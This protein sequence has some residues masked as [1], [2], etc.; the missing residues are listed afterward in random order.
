MDCY[1]YK[2]KYKT[3]GFIFTKSDQNYNKTE[4]YKW[5][6]PEYLTIDFLAIKDQEVKNQYI[7]NVGITIDMASKFNLVTNDAYS[8]LINPF[9]FKMDSYKPV[10]FYNSLKP[11]IYYYADD[12]M[13][14]LSGKIIELSLDKNL[15]WK[16][17]KIRTDR[18]VELQSGKYFGNNYRVAEITLQSIINPLSLKELIS[19]HN[20]LINNMYFT[21]QD[22]TYADIKKFNNYVKRMLIQRYQNTKIVLDLASGRA[23]DLNKYINANVKN[24]IMLEIDKDA[25][26]E[27]INR[28]Y[29][30]LTKPY[31]KGCNLV[32]L[33]TDLNNTYTNNIKLIDDA[34][35]DSDTFI[36]NNNIPTNGL[37]KLKHSI[38]VIFCH[39]AFHYMLFN[40]KSTKNIISFIDHYLSVNGVFIITIFNAQNVFQLL[41]LHKG[42][43][44]NN[45]YKIEY[46]G[47]MP[48]IFSGFGHI[49]DVL[50]PLSNKTQKEPL[51]DLFALDKI[52]NIFNIKR[53]EEKNFG[54]V[55]MDNETQHKFTDPN[56][57]QFINLYKYVIYK[58]F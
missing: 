51:I 42:K 55:H 8:N 30:I 33:Q 12:I 3:D 13:D 24:L 50:L 46:V 25:I 21:K 39:F 35:I 56:D 44:A 28:K 2:T 27:I 41:K 22:E 4:N 20:N 37:S 36:Q 18:Q 54:D 32:V 40:E 49:I 47:K 15:N 7:L 57:K 52:F 1:K 17:H 10:P 45:K 5:K 6:P 34:L 38:P 26:S 11:N 14:N 43:W 48:S 29:N 31:N 58:K 16:F 23:G 53:V 19:T 9:N